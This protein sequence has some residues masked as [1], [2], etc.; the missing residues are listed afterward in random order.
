MA[1]YTVVSFDISTKTNPKG[2]D[3]I[4][5]SL[6]L[7]NS[8]NN[9]KKVTYELH[10]DTRHTL[11]AINTVLHNSLNLAISN[12]I[13]IEISEFLERMY[14]FIKLPVLQSDRKIKKEQYQYTAHKI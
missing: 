9:S 8:S 7:L 2:F 12:H 3:Y 13:K 4:E 11:N 5:L 10:D 14:I 1:N 6:D